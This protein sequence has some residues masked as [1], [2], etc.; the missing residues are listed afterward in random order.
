MKLHD[1]NRCK[2]QAGK[3][4]P[5]PSPPPRLYSPSMTHKN[6]WLVQSRITPEA[7]AA[8]I[9]YSSVLRQVLFNRGYA[10]E[11]QAE[12]FFRAQVDFDTN[13]FLIKGMDAAVTR[14]QSALTAGEPI[15]VYG[16][17]D[18]D[19]VTATALL[20]EALQK[21]G[22]VVQPYIPNRF[23][24][25]YGLN[26][27]ALTQ[28]HSQGVKLVITVDCGIR[29]P[30]EARHARAIG[31]D[32]IISDH[33]EPAGEIPD[34]LAVVNPKQ[35]GDTY[36][37]KYLAGV[38][39]AYKIAEAL[40]QER[41]KRKEEDS[42]VFPLS[43]LLDLVALGTVADLAP[44]TGENRALVRKGLEQMRQT[45]R[46]GLFSLAA[47]AGVAMPKITAGSIGFMFGPRLNA[48]GRL[49]KA[50]ASF[51]LLTTTSPQEAGTL[52]QQLDVQNRERQVLTKE[53]QTQAEGL[54]LEGQKDSLL[55]FAIH[56]DFN[57][58]VVGLAASRLQE[59]YY[60]PAIVGNYG[61]E[62]TRCSCRSIP[63]FHITR[64][65]DECADLLV[66]HGGH[67]GAAGFTVR[68]ENIGALT[69]RLGEIAKRELEGRD[70]RH[71]LV[72][73][74][75]V[76]FQ[77]LTFDLVGQLNA[78]QPTGYG[79]PDAVFISRGVQVKSSRAVGADARH[80]KLNLSDGKT[81]LDA[82]GFRLGGLLANL[83]KVVDVL[84]TLEVNEY[85]GR[86]SLQLN[87]KDVKAVGVA[88]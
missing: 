21:L 31:L 20:V 80:L 25:G 27:E 4:L 38:G 78:L 7:D 44:L 57:H 82:I 59:L 33:H 84:Y 5:S 26:N 70:L 87:L 28:L 75:E 13:P 24:E 63:E 37:E 17:Y 58:G 52:A 32:L 76:A 74:V 35:E 16:D 83:P 29:S 45:T 62:T 48:S 50:I 42:F 22:G 65:L 86:S 18:V 46:Q 54:A 66:R 8:L 11:A 67:A 15:A 12:S 77:S 30:E 64:A 36:P 55:L 40:V 41:G 9:K 61:P 60:R 51:N 1:T 79:N 68:N 53:I 69:T 34:A 81:T 6:R 10:T 23:E 56:P 47:I 3:S 71:S 73:D 14:I 85:N 88:D 72:A 2:L 43:S 19:G 49:D 39:L